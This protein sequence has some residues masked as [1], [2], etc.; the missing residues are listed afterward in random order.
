MQFIAVDRI[1]GANKGFIQQPSET[2]AITRIQAKGTY[3]FNKR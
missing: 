1:Y 2:L 3:I